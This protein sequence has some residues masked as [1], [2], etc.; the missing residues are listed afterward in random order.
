MIKKI[1]QYFFIG[2]IFFPLLF[3]LVLSLGRHWEFPKLLPQEV[4]ILNWIQI[5]NTETNFLILFFQSVAISTFIAFI[6]TSFSFLISKS[7][8]YSKNKF[9]YLILAYVPYLLSPIIMGILFHYFFIITNL[10]GTLF[11]VLIAQF[12]I[13]FPFG[14]IIFSSFWN[15]NIKSIEEL[16]YTLGSSVKQT[17]LKV[18]LPI[19]KNTLLLCFFQIFLIS[20]FEYGL[21]NLIGIGKIRTLTISVFKFI[22]E[23]NIF[24]AA[25]ASFLL[26]I[27]PMIVVYINKKLLFF[28]QK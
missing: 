28:T 17:Y 27:P 22:H 20:W 7:I 15:Q 6:V 13:S 4:S 11:G 23:A 2:T 25:L 16:S 26:V 8:A 10:T 19:S 1:A 18:V 14:I 12:L 5:Q 9:F 21:T 3:L 24:Y